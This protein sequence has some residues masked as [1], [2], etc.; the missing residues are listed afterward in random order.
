MI[1]IIWLLFAQKYTQPLFKYQVGPI[2]ICD[3]LIQWPFNASLRPGA[4]IQ[5][6]FSVKDCVLIVEEQFLD[7]GEYLEVRQSD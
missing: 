3:R 2:I 1:E 6:S 4:E 7:I 5:A